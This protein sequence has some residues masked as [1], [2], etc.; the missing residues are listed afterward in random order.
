MGIDKVM[1]AV[2]YPQEEHRPAVEAIDKAPMGKED[3]AK[4]LYKNAERVFGIK[5]T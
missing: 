4:F 2:D 1:F 3:R 5:S